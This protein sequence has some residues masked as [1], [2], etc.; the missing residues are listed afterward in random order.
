[1]SFYHTP[2]ATVTTPFPAPVLFDSF[3]M[4]KSRRDGSFHGEGKR[5]RILI[6][7]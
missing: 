2:P 1:M 5:E 4:R 7:G 6:R 3:T